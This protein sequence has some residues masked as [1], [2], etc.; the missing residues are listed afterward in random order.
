MEWCALGR[1]LP[2]PKKFNMTCMWGDADVTG[3]YIIK[4]VGNLK[5]KDWQATNKGNG[6]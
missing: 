1:V 4:D 3:K 2:K 6:P 5:K